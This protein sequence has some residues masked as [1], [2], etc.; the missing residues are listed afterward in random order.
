MK[1][2]FVTAPGGALPPGIN[3]RTGTVE[4]RSPS[5]LFWKRVDTV[6]AFACLVSKAAA[7]FLIAFILLWLIFALPG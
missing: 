7:G 6:V 5:P 3:R 4:N 2:R 1:P